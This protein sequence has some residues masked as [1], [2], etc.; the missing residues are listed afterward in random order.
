MLKGDRWK[1]EKKCASTTNIAREAS[2]AFLE[3][4][5]NGD[6]ILEFDEF[7]EA[8]RRLR[9]RAN[10]AGVSEGTELLNATD[11]EELRQ[12]FDGIDSDKSGTIE[13]D[14]YFLWTLDMA[15]AQGCG[16]ESLFRKYDTSGEGM[17]DANEFALAVEDLGFSA[18]FAH[19]LFVD[20][21]DDNSGAVS[22]SEITQTLK[23]RVGGVS[24]ESKKLL[25][26]LAFHDAKSWNSSQRIDTKTGKMTVGGDSGANVQVLTLDRLK[27]E[28][29]EP[30][31]GP[32]AESLRKQ[33]QHLLSLNHLRDSDLY[34]LMT[35]PLVKGDAS[36]PLN[37][38]CWKDG[39][40]RKRAKG[41]RPR[42]TR[43]SRERDCLPALQLL[44]GPHRAAL[45]PPPV[46]RPA[47]PRAAR[48][49]P[50][51]LQ[52]HRLRQDGLDRLCGAS[53]VDDGQD[54]SHHPRARGALA[55]GAHRRRI[56]ARPQVGPLLSPPR[57]RRHAVSG[58]AR[59][60]RSGV[61]TRLASADWTGRLDRP[62][63][64]LATPRQRS[65]R[66]T[67]RAQLQ[68]VPQAASRRARRDRLLPDL[69]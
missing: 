16:L 29:A 45:E 42:E 53:G 28:G 66:S 39:M 46:H 6:G 13:M 58:G 5:V 10:S 8:I 62:I 9:F 49:A 15:T 2:L 14:E 54:A 38:E 33:I 68:R 35:M 32:D 61:R 48:P 67:S 20:L 17:L 52:A 7:K 3:A 23:E 26:T 43:H 41:Q 36:I 51:H 1:L 27:L 24:E 44:V 34:N 21:D 65:P 37:A 12:L 60:H 59:A 19:D 25:T 57:D 69:T 11:E 18:T 30:L 56:S 40:R 47:V 4:D 22:Y 31:V 63:G 64:R 55:L 50:Q